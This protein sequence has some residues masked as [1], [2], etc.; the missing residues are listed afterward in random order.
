V[1]T[2]HQIDL[3]EVILADKLLDGVVKNFPDWKQKSEAGIISGGEIILQETDMVRP[4]KGL[5]PGIHLTISLISF[6]KGRNF[7]GLA[8]DTIKLIKETKDEEGRL[9]M[10]GINV[11][12]QMTLDRPVVKAGANTSYSASGDGLSLLEYLG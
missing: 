7:D 1:L 10:S 3:I 4:M 9:F 5:K 8:Q 11:F 12:V 6:K 2:G